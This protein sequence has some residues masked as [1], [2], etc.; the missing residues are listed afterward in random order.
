MCEKHILK[1]REIVYL[2]LKCSVRRISC[3]IFNR[4]L[5]SQSFVTV[6]GKDQSEKSRVPRFFSPSIPEFPVDQRSR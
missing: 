5:K 3:S 4:S 2:S 1:I 6:S